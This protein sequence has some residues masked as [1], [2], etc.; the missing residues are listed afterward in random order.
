MP[1]KRFFMIS[2]LVFVH[3]VSASTFHNNRRRYVLKKEKYKIY[4][5]FYSR[6]KELQ[7]WNNKMS[8]ILKSSSPSAVQARIHGLQKR[9][10]QPM[11]NQEKPYLANTCKDMC[12]RRE[13][14]SKIPRAQRT[15]GM[16]RNGNRNG[17][18]FGRMC[19]NTC[20]AKAEKNKRRSL[21]E[22]EKISKE[23]KKCKKVLFLRKK[24]SSRSQSPKVNGKKRHKKKEKKERKKVSYK[25]KKARK[26]SVGRFCL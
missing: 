25:V 21:S 10:N 11:K 23:R 24:T 12:K 5:K 6:L 16:V 8:T 9:F 19:K 17:R 1:G 15:G 22:M 26:T 2:L 18:R 20:I 7:N 4:F 14:R 13:S 3:I